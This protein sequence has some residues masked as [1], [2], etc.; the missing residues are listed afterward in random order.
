LARRARESLSDL[1][2]SSEFDMRDPYYRYIHKG[3]AFKIAPNLHNWSALQE[4]ILR[5][6]VTIVVFPAEGPD[7]LIDEPL[8]SSHHRPTDWVIMG[9]GA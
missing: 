5:R 7:E 8:L 4:A 9:G 1:G 2:L 3:V 6:R